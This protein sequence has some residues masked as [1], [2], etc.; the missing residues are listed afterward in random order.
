VDFRQL[1]C[2]VGARDPG[3]PAFFEPDECE[4]YEMGG[5]LRG[6]LVCLQA[7]ECLQGI[8]CVPRAS[9]SQDVQTLHP[10]YSCSSGSIWGATL[11]FLHETD[12]S[13]VHVA[14]LEHTIQTLRIVVLNPPVSCLYFCRR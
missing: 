1:T 4:G 2:L 14:L 5:E 13:L 7:E 8:R 10:L 11:F 9:E 6:R 12:K 3:D